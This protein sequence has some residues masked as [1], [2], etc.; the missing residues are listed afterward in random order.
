[1]SKMERE[2]T[3]QNFNLFIIKKKNTLRD[4]QIGLRLELSPLMILQCQTLPIT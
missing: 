4:S 1:M 3:R 2:A